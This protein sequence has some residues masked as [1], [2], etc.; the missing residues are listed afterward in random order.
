MAA[1]G[2]ACVGAVYGG[3]GGAIVLVWWIWLTNGALRS[4]A[5]LT[6]EIGREKELREGTPP[7]ET[8]NRPARQA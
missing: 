4:G 8:L 3:F 1:A 7:R 6:A 5:E 2:V